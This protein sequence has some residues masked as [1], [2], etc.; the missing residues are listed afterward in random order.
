MF[1]YL[2]LQIFI[3]CFILTS[4]SFPLFLKVTDI[5]SAKLLISLSLSKT[6][7]SFL[8]RRLHL[9]KPCRTPSRSLSPTPIAHM[10]NA[11]SWSWH[12]CFSMPGSYP[13]LQIPYSLTVLPTTWHCPL[14]SNIELSVL[15]TCVSHSRT[16]THIVLVSWPRP[17]ALSSWE[18][19]LHDSRFNSRSPALWSPY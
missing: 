14:S 11:G 10:I 2:S 13:P 19:S 3:C 15:I 8:W 9:Q 6:G 5:A 7:S 18:N 16:L 4:L 12:I 1:Y 17:S